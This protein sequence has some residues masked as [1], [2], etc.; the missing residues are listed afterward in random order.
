MKPASRIV[1]LALFIACTAAP[2][3]SQHYYYIRSDAGQP[4]GQTTN[5]AA[6]DDVVGPG[7]WSTQYYETLTVNQVFSPS[8]TFIFMEGGDSSFS[9]FQSF[10]QANLTTIYN[11]VHS[12]GAL[13]IISAPNDPLT[14]ATVTLPD[15]IT[16]QSD[17]FYASAASSASG[18]DMSNVLFHTPNSTGYQFNGDF[19]SHGYFTGQ[20]VTALMESNLNE[21]VL[22][23]DK[24]G[25][26][27]MIFGGMTTDNFQLPQPAAHLF[28]EN[29]ITYMASY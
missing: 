29:I 14:S 1:R 11:W 9:A 28:L 19:F 15:S 4:W 13:L 7:N 2:A 20:N 3:L 22:G 5:E 12:G 18:T 6:M 26:G 17:A 10:M 25:S 16:L 23:V 24:I 21:V 8:T 27:I